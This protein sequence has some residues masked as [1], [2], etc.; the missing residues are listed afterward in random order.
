MKTTKTL[1]FSSYCI[2]HSKKSIPYD[3]PH[4]FTIIKFKN[5]LFVT[6]WNQ[7][8]QWPKVLVKG[9]SDKLVKQQIL[10]TRKFIRNNLLNQVSKNT[11]STKWYCNFIHHHCTM[12]LMGWNYNIMLSLLKMSWWWTFVFCCPW[13][14]LWKT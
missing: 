8:E 12:C 5:K 4:W 3:P 10:Q 7:L 9:Y 11:D 14:L 2:Y 1:K 13:L 6:E